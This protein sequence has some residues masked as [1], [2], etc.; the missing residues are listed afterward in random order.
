MTECESDGSHD[1]IGL[2][3]TDVQWSEFKAFLETGVLPD[4]LT[5]PALK[6]RYKRICG[7]L[8]RKQH[9]QFRLT[10]G[11]VECSGADGVYLE[12]I[13]R[14]DGERRRG[15]IK[16]VHEELTHASWSK[17]FAGIKH[18]FRNITEEDVQMYIRDCVVCLRTGNAR[19]NMRDITPVLAEH[20]HQH[21]QIDL[22]DMKRY[23]AFNDGFSWI[24]C[25]IDVFSKFLWTIPLFGKDA[26]EVEI[27]LWHLFQYVGAPE[28]LH[29][30]NGGEFRN[31][32][33]RRLCDHFKIEQRHGKA[34]KPT[35][36]GQ[37]ER[38]N[39]TLYRRIQK[40]LLSALEDNQHPECS[41]AALD[42][43]HLQEEEKED[44]QA[45]G[46]NKNPEICDA[47]AACDVEYGV[48]KRWI[49]SLDAVT[50]A[51][52][53]SVH[54]AFD[55]K[56][57]PHE[58]HRG[59]PDRFYLNRDRQ[60]ESGSKSSEDGGAVPI[61]EPSMDSVK[62][63]IDVRR[64]VADAAERTRKKYVEKYVSA[65]SVHCRRNSL[66]EGD[67][68][69]ARPQR[70]NNAAHRQLPL[71]PTYSVMGTVVSI[72]GNNT[73]DVQVS[74]HSGAFVRKNFNLRAVKRIPKVND[75]P[76]APKEA[77]DQLSMRKRGRPRKGNPGK[78]VE[79]AP[80][81]NEPVAKKSRS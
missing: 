16:S 11:V 33:I 71:E 7:V 6:L 18:R 63:F 75:V 35:T 62:R 28:V 47:S 31:V 78:R 45:E 51:Y 59:F 66:H 22:I 20:P 27:A 41:S 39:Q 30:D 49:D 65:A 40:H 25:V 2:D 54:R 5:T 42:F 72:K 24:L 53:A 3:K 55:D 61:Q 79:E 80:S 48:R 67:T 52:N 68:V 10:D 38:C 17:T 15:I 57:S 43:R 32:G 60:A 9:R 58:V 50:R 8:G 4:T 77:L 69:I 19:S 34:R 74:T 26:D 37:V 56:M 23:D 76:E 29:S 14:F 64:E 36:Q 1:R 81:E 44:E 73:V 46:E 21:W 12:W 70:T 13:P